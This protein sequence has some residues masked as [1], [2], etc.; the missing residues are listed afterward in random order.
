MTS[1]L[2]DVDNIIDDIRGNRDLV[3]E[4]RTML[5]AWQGFFEQDPQ[6]TVGEQKHVHS[7][8]VQIREIIGRSYGVESEA[9]VKAGLERQIQKSMQRLRRRIE[10]Q[11]KAEAER[12]RRQ[13]EAE[14]QAGAEEQEEAK[15]E[16]GPEEQVGFSI[17]EHADL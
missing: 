6:R 2:A 14:E 17:N 7:L 4:F 11:R 8:A 5:N 16:T 13:A 9:T 15:K 1:T 10:E 3:E 12:Q